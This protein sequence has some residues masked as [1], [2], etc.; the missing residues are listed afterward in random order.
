MSLLDVIGGDFGQPIELT[1]ID[2]DTNAA[3]DISGY[4][5]VQMI[6]TNPAGTVTT[7]TAAFKTDGSDGIITYT[8]EDGLLT[9]GVWD[10]RGR[11]I[12]GS[13]AQLTTTKHNFEVLD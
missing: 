1:F 4:V 12:N 9:A 6:F 13:T 10:V 7:K 3:A 5:T 8:P 2:V 11:V